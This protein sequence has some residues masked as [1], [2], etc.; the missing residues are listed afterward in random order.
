MSG[1]HSSSSASWTSPGAGI[2]GG[3]EGNSEAL[4]IVI[5]FFAGLAMYNA[6]EL[7]IMIFLTFKNYRGKHTEGAM[8]SLI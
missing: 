5:V 8:V 1:N 2:T 3:Y 6:C 4:R 7:A